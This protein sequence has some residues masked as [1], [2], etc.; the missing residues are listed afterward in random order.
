MHHRVDS[1]QEWHEAVLKKGNIATL[2]HRRK[3][4]RSCGFQDLRNI[5]C[6][7]QVGLEET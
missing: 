3:D 1:L 4:F 6:K 2:D 7:K 5:S